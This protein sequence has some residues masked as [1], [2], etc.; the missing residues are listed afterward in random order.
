MKKDDLKIPYITVI[1]LSLIALFPLPYAY[2][3]FLKIVVTFCAGATAYFNYKNGNKNIIMW[4]CVV[5]AIL[6]NPI[7]PIHLTKEIWMGVNMF[8]SGLFGYL[9]YGLT[10]R[11]KS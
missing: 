3:T 7:A 5:V 11:E 2:Y 10:K 9:F 8:V 4:L 6:F 1:I